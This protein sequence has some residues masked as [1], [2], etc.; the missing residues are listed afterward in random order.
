MFSKELLLTLSIN[1]IITIIVVFILFRM[2][3]NKIRY[4]F[5]RLDKKLNQNNQLLPNNYN[6]NIDDINNTPLKEVRYTTKNVEQND[7]DSYIDPMNE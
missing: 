1:T 3:D 4:Y 5:K 2:Q 6:N 7:I